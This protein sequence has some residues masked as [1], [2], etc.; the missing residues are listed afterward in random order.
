V[1]KKQGE[2]DKNSDCSYGMSAKNN[3]SS[4]IA[5]SLATPK[6]KIQTI[7]QRLALPLN[8]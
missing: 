3:T 7:I 1:D 5:I 6:G 2:M 4:L 8:L